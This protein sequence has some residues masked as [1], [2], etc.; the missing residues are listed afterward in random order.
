MQEQLTAHLLVYL[1]LNYHYFEE[2]PYPN[3]PKPC[4]SSMWSWIQVSYAADAWKFYWIFYEVPLVHL[5]I[6]IFGLKCFYNGLKFLPQK[7]LE[8]PCVHLHICL[9]WNFVMVG[10]WVCETHFWA[11]FYEVSSMHLVHICGMNSI[12]I[13]ECSLGMWDID[14]LHNKLGLG[15]YQ[16]IP[17]SWWST[18]KTHKLRSWVQVP[19][20][21][22]F[23]MD[24]CVVGST[25]CR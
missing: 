3:G 7:F 4:L 20:A 25:V 15:S 10:E 12:M 24:P 19:P 6:C 1:H 16:N 5:H 22:P 18:S 23:G 8:L 21:A 14:F 2:Y 17:L 9:G 11:R 13:W